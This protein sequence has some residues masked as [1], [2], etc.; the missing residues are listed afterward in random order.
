M[1]RPAIA[2]VKY[3][4]DY[5]TTETGQADDEPQRPRQEGK[6]WQPRSRQDQEIFLGQVCPELGFDMVEDWVALY[7]SAGLDRL[8]AGK[9]RLR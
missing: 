4:N 3:S 5:L 9:G 7:A 1:I 2:I 8:E 6:R